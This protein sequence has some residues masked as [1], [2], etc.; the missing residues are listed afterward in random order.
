M[1]VY[2][3]IHWNIY[4]ILPFQRNFNLINGERSLGKTY[5]CQMFVLDKC[6]TKGCE[7]VYIVRTQDEKKQG[8]LE[9]SFKKVTMV[10]FPD[11]I[12]EYT[13][14]EMYLVIEDIETDTKEKILLGYCIALSESV[15]VK[16]RSFPRVKY[17]I[18]DEYMLE[19]NQNATYVTGW[20][21]PNLLLSIYH[22]IDREDDRVIAFLL[23]N[24]TKFHNPYHIHKSFN[25]PPIQKGG[26]WT[27]ENVLFQ[28]AVGGTALKEKKSKS[29]FLR[30]LEGTDYGTY[31]KDGD[32]VYDNYS[33][34]EKLTTNAR[35]NMTIEF[36]GLRYGVYSSYNQGLIYISDKI[37]ESCKLKYALTV[38]DHKENTMLTKSREV[39]QLKW[40]ADNYK[41][42]NVRFVSMEIK[43][44]LEKGIAML[45]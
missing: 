27:S 9:E 22:T 37:D 14:D 43:A 20:N 13:K 7:F 12:F 1:N 26:I 16:K 18:F 44:R 15:K 40:L 17:M 21:E 29:K 38:D 39:T 41:R 8:I 23:G 25:V 42:G 31:A 33:F 35:Y 4:E 36:E 32:Y 5:T 24:N 10:E 19:S 3:G 11:I 45:L 6:I 30:M 34:I 28:Y 2:D